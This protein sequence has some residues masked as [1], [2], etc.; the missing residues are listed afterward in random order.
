VLDDDGGGAQEE[1]SGTASG[2]VI[3]L[4]NNTFPEGNP[5]GY[6]VGTLRTVVDGIVTPANYALVPG[7]GADHN[8]LFRVAS[9]G[10]EA[11]IT[12]DHESLAA[13]SVRVRAI[14]A[15]GQAEEVLGITVVDDRTEDNDGD[16]L[17]ELDEEE[18]YGTD[19]Q[20]PDSDGDSLADNVEV[21]LASLGFHPAIDNTALIAALEGSTGFFTSKSIVNA[22]ADNL[23][24]QKRPDGQFLLHFQLQELDEATKNW[25]DLGPPADWLY[26]GGE[27]KHFFRIEVE[28]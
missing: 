24:V 7:A 21:G 17:T 11:L 9:G 5:V 28:E 1:D 16:S 3:S 22:N 2:T 13:Y 25:L 27:D 15:G 8:G 6:R 4:D 12:A 14:Y 10:L 26:N 23:F 20:N 19:D 18:L